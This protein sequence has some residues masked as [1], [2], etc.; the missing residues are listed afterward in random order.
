MA[1]RR[2]QPLGELFGLTTWR[3]LDGADAGRG[4]GAAPCSHEARRARLR[5][6]RSSDL[7]TDEGRT[8]LSAGNV[9][10]IQSG[11]GNGTG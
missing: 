2:K 4:L 1:G 10:R 11:T 8:R 5:A 6:A 9:R 7:H 3:E